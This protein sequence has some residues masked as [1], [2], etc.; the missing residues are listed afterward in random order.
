MK[1]VTEALELEDTIK[2]YEHPCQ[3]ANTLTHVSNVY[4]SVPQ[5]MGFHLI[6][7]FGFTVI[8]F[9]IGILTW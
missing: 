7:L 1:F 3:Q 9:E 4:Y 2:N 6:T 8:V 5:V